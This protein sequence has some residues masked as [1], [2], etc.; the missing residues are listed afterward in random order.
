MLSYHFQDLDFYV[1]V[2]K[3]LLQIFIYTMTLIT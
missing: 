3:L 2:S 1:I